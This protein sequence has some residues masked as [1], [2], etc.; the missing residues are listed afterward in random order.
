MEKFDITIHSLH[1]VQEFVSLAARQPFA[2]TVGNENQ[3]IDGKDFMGMFCLDYSRPL[4]V[5]VQCSFEEYDRFRQ[6]AAKFLV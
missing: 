1:E 5:S 3:S 4:Q 6:C 2:V